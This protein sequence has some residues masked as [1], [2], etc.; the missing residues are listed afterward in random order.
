MRIDPTSIGFHH[1]HANPVL[2]VADLA[3]VSAIA[4]VWLDILPAV[5]AIFA[6]MWYGILI[7]ESKTVR[8]WTHR[9]TKNE[10]EERVEIAAMTDAEKDQN[11]T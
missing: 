10:V 3:A 5:A 6:A 11:L 9:L 2:V 7:W 8:G 4:G 1:P